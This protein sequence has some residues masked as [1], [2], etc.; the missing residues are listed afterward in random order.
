MDPFYWDHHQQQQP[1]HYHH[2]LHQQHHQPVLPPPPPPLQPHLQQQQQQ[3]LDHSQRL[4][5]GTSASVAAVVATADTRQNDADNAS[6]DSYLT[7]S[8]VSTTIIWCYACDMTPL[9]R[10]R[11]I[12]KLHKIWNCAFRIIPMFSIIGRGQR[13]L[14]CKRGKTFFSGWVVTGQWISAQ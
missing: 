9:V 2:H 13:R 6:D 14:A 7:S 3:Q 1:H 12:K 4:Q 5:D 11:V 10:Y 8:H